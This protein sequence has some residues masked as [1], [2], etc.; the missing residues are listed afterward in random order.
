MPF[1][2]SFTYSKRQSLLWTLG[3]NRPKTGL[4]ERERREKG[5][6]APWWP[7]KTCPHPTLRPGSMAYFKIR[8]FEDIIR[9]LEET[10]S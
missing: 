6:G 2:G 10:A 7:P 4:W 1:I 9:D 5:Q 3:S 8:V